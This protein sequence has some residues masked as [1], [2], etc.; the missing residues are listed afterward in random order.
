[1][2]YT[3]QDIHQ[4]VPRSKWDVV[5]ENPEDNHVLGNIQLLINELETVKGKGVSTGVTLTTLQNILSAGKNEMNE[6]VG[7]SGIQLLPTFFCNVTNELINGGRYGLDADKKNRIRDLIGYVAAGLNIEPVQAGD[8]E[9]TEE[10]K[11]AAKIIRE[12]GRKAVEEELKQN[13]DALKVPESF[14]AYQELEEEKAE[15]EKMPKRVLIS[16]KKEEMKQKLAAHSTKIFSIRRAGNARRNKKAKL[17]E[18][19]V[20]GADMNRWTRKMNEC[21]TLQQFLRNTSYEDLRSLAA[22]GHGGAM[23]KA[24]SKYVC[25]LDRFPGDIPSAYYLP[26]ALVIRQMCEKNQLSFNYNKY[27]WIIKK[28]LEN[29]THEHKGDNSNKNKKIPKRMGK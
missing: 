15:V 7:D 2:P 17:Q 11:E 16:A 3:I 28:N 18:T 10:Q 13:P 24:F 25:N 9:V 6:S 12:S 26:T 14:N 27:D 5:N 23:E 1:M 19:T 4:F 8:F 20:D 29:S 22:E 21:E